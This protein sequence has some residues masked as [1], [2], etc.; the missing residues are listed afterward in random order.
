VLDAKMTKPLPKILTTRNPDFKHNT[1]GETPSDHPN[2]EIV[3][4]PWYVRVLI[5]FCY[6]YLSSLLG[7]W[8]GLNFVPIPGDPYPLLDAGAKFLVIA[9]LAFLTT[10]PVTI[11]NIITFLGELD[12]SIP[13]LAS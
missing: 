8:L 9:Q 6:T 1:T 5:R 12:K 7:L 4:R 2:V 13:D 3:T 10:A 11:K